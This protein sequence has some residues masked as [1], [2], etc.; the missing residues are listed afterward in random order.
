MKMTSTCAN[1]NSK[2]R[3]KTKALRA[4]TCPKMHSNSSSPAQ[5]SQNLNQTCTNVSFPSYCVPRYTSDRHFFTRRNKPAT[6]LIALMME[7]VQTS[8]TSVNS[9]QSTRRYNPQAPPWEPQVIP[10][11]CLV[12]LRSR[13]LCSAAGGSYRRLRETHLLVP[14]TLRTSDV[15]S[16][17]C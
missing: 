5:W 3:L 11:S 9:P 17:R 12:D 15:P 7:A 10:A 6:N 13:V 14:G 16:E 8:E 1:I 4:F 2:P